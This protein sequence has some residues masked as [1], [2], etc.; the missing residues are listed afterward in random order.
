[1]L[2][3]DFEERVPK[4]KREQYKKMRGVTSTDGDVFS[5]RDTPEASSKIDISWKEY[6]EDLNELSLRVGQ[7]GSFSFVHGLEPHGVFP[8]IFISFQLGKRLVNGPE[9]LLLA[10]E[11]PESLLVVDGSCAD[12]A[13][14]I[15]YRVKVKTASIYL[16]PSKKRVCSP[17]LAVI[18]VAG[19]VRFPYERVLDDA[20]IV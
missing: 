13:S 11:T 8:A 19:S 2:T 7:L 14:L 6:L 15:P 3:D 10:N 5:I 20:E 1:M 9:V 18:E 12:G 4:E 16:E 17:E